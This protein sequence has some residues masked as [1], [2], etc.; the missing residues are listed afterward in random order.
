[1]N[2]RG[3]PTPYVKTFSMADATR[4]KLA[5]KNVWASY[6]DVMLVARARSACMRAGFPDVLK[7][8]I[9][10][11]EAA[12][13]PSEDEQVKEARPTSD[14]PT[15]LRASAV[16]LETGEVLDEGTSDKDLPAALEASLVVAGGAAPVPTSVLAEGT[17]L[18]R[19]SGV[20]SEDGAAPSLLL[21]E[22]E[23]PMDE[24]VLINEKD[25]RYFHVCREQGHHPKDS[26]KEWL[27]AK[28][29]ISSTSEI[30][31]EW[32]EDICARLRDP[33]PL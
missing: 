3:R 30:H 21:D 22:L 11:E 7:G 1:M 24:P 27:Q 16:D 28:Y 9:T 18:P 20:V 6:P 26:T 13:Y 4:A 15:P 19:S 32:L 25:R 17:N 29:G 12:D 10:R 31:K 2:R 23:V 14:L 5:G 8:V 33:M